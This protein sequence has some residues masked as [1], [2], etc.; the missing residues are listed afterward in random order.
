MKTMLTHHHLTDELVDDKRGHAI[1]L[2]K[3]DGIAEPHSMQVQP[4]VR[5]EREGLHETQK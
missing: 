4:H 5:G 3:L 1:L 2:T